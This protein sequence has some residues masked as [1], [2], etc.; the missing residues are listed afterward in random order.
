[1]KTALMFGVLFCSSL[2]LPPMTFA[3]S[4]PSAPNGQSQAN[5]GQTTIVGCLSQTGNT[6]TLIDTRGRVYDLTGDSALLA[7]YEGAKI[8]VSGVFANAAPQASS[9]SSVPG[10][11]AYSGTANTGAGISEQGHGSFSVIGVTKAAD[12]C[13]MHN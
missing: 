5:P 7:P 2:F 9:P 8:E 6:Y 13:S 12:T 10:S 4:A 11:T 3:Q 1:M